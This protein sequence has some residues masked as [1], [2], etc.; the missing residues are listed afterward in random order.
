MDL[1]RE[2]LADDP[3]HAFAIV[4]AATL[5]AESF[6]ADAEA[7]IAPLVNDT[8]S[9]AGAR[10]RAALLGARFALERGEPDS[11]ALMLDLA[12]DLARDNDWP[13]LDVLALRVALDVLN[14]RRRR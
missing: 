14:G 1:F 4:G 2:V 5:L 13:L 9:R 10:L 6:E 11:A 7:R 12:G 8:N 3:N